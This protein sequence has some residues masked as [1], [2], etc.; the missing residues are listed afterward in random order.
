MKG[1]ERR[2]F[3]H[4]R[5]G[6]SLEVRA[7]EGWPEGRGSGNERDKE[8]EERVARNRGSRGVAGARRGMNRK[9]GKTARE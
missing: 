8:K 2:N 6:G 4:N 5:K 7:T 9:F 3:H 1:K